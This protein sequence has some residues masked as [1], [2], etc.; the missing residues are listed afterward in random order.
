MDDFAYGEPQ[1]VPEPTTMAL[2][3]VGLLAAGGAGAAA[4]RSRAG[5]TSPILA[6]QQH[7]WPEAA[8][9]DPLIT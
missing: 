8:R 6:G 9:W 1:A 3:G 4:D 2:L 5:L 7:S